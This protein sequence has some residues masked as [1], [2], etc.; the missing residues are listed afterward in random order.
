MSFAT[1]RYLRDPR[2]AVVTL[3]LL[4]LAGLAMLG[5][6]ERPEYPTPFWFT[7]IVYGVTNL[8]YMASRLSVFLSPRVQRAVFVFD[9][10][11]V[12]ALIVLRGSN[13]PEFILAYFTL[14]LMAAMVQ[15]VGSAALNAVVVCSV[16]AAVSR[17]GADPRTL[18]TFPV[19]SQFAFF[20]V[21]A[22]FMSQLA[23]SGREQARERVRGEQERLRLEET[24]AD[25]TRDLSRSE[26]ELDA[27]RRRL[28]AADRLAT[29]GTL[30]AGVAHD[31]RNPVAALKAALD[32]APSLLDEM[33][34][35]PLDGPRADPGVML[36]SAVDDARAACDHLHR[37][38]LDLTA[39]ARST[40]AAPVA[41]AGTHAVE[42]AA[43]LLRHR[44]K[45][46]LRIEVRSTTMRS[47]LADPGRLQ[48]V[49]LNLG[50]NALD[51]MEACGGTLTLAVDDGPPG[52]V[53]FRVEDTG[54]GMTD[55]TATKALHGFFTTKPAGKGTGLGLHLVHEI[56]EAHGARLDLTSSPGQGT[57]FRIEWP[58]DVRRPDGGPDHDVTD[59]D[60]ADRGRRGEHSPCA[61]ADAP[62]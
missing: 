25:R 35:A 6:A 55:S 3:R 11:V 39:V 22:L 42:S 15:G 13:V 16:F 7:L 23:E 28:A 27:A 31:I 56:V 2:D 54:V 29:L 47:A 19:L 44:A 52:R 32:E 36:R 45:P 9:V 38:A 1:G 62:A 46:P 50:G 34:A 41:V 5:L 49:L 17:W 48:Q 53:V 33:G 59:A 18:L 20:F 24:V 8:G 14:V 4:V 58:A 43:R 60:P 12:S 51:A 61:R 21:V 10:L 57:K 37:L 30:A 40:P 26:E